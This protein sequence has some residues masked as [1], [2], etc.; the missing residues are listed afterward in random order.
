MS[1][2]TIEDLGKELIQ[3]RCFIWDALPAPKEEFDV[4]EI[5]DLL[6]EAGFALCP[7]C[8]CYCYARELASV[9]GICQE[10]IDVKELYKISERL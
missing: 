6:T 5:F 3:R 9:E 1:E 7:K 10:C 8:V 4:D 2:F